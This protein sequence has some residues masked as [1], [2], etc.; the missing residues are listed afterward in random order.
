VGSVDVIAMFDVDLLTTVLGLGVLVLVVTT[1]IM[2]LEFLPGARQR[3]LRHPH[4]RAL[5]AGA[6]LAVADAR[7]RAAAASVEL[8]IATPVSGQIIDLSDDR[9][10]DRQMSV[11]Q[12]TALATHFAETDPQRVAEVISQWIRADL[13]EEPDARL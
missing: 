9:W 1:T 12:A 3:Q 2:L 4:Q 13:T 11:E 10:Q 5:S 7:A 8:R 6:A